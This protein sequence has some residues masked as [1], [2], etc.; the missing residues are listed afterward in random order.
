MSKVANSSIIEQQ[1]KSDKPKITWADLSESQRETLLTLAI[2]SQQLGK[3]ASLPKI[4]EVFGTTKQNLHHQK[5]DRQKIDDQ[6]GNH[7]SA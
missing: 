1:S 5:K 4:A 7:E 3:I 2:I 6:K